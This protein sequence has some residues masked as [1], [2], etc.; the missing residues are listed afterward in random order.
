MALK[1]ADVEAYFQAEVEAERLAQDL[2][3]NEGRVAELD[4]MKSGL[5]TTLYNCPQCNRLIWYRGGGGGDWEFFTPEREPL[6]P[7]EK[8][9]L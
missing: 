1:G 5:Q 3:H 7:A 6:E 2:E 9:A 8:K 4:V